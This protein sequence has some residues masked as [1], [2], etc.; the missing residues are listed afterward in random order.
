MD[1]INTDICQN[2]YDETKMGETRAREER[3]LKS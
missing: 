2:K 1:L 3:P